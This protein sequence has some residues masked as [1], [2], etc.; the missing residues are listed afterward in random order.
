M[1]NEAQSCDMQKMATHF[2]CPAGTRDSQVPPNNRVRRK[3]A[4]ERGLEG[5]ARWGGRLS[6]GR[7]LAVTGL[8]F[9]SQRQEGRVVTL[10]PACLLAEA[11]ARL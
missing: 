11:A 1:D 10:H 4:G 7:T 5:G 9:A 8:S 3:L 6:A 2:V